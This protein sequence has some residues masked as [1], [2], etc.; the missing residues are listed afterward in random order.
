[1]GGGTIGPRNATVGAGGM[2][3]GTIGPNF[4]LVVVGAIG[5]TMWLLAMA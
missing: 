2:G 5:D 4:A 1:M 3:G